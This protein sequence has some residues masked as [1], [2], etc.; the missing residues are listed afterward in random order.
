[1][2][3]AIAK[4]SVTDY[5]G[6]QR[7]IIYLVSSTQKIVDA[8][9]AWCFTDGHAVEAIT[10]YYN[11]SESLEELDWAAID[12]FDFR[13]TVSDP[14]KLEKQAEF[15]VHNNVPWMCVESITVKDLGMKTI[16]EK[17]LNETNSQHRPNININRNWYYNPRGGQE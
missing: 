15:L 16:I 11:D 8:E 4:G 10:E 13:S 17:I 12:A 7:E 9:C 6:T 1:M 3:I 14:D 5:L 2:M